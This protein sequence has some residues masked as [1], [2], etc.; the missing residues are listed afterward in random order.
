[1]QFL[2]AFYQY[3]VIIYYVLIFNY[4]ETLPCPTHTIYYKSIIWRLLWEIYL[5]ADATTTHAVTHAQILVE[6]LGEE[7]TTTVAGGLLSFY[8][9]AADAAA[10]IPVVAAMVV[11]ITTTT[12]AA[13]SS[14][15]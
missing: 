5:L 11:V 15:F 1:M 8:S 2:Q 10:T 7:A 9:F 3:I 6:I 13:Q 14:G 12:A 4:T